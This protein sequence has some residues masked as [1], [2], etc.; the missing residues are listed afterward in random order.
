MS[1]WLE[2]LYTE[3]VL[4]EPSLESTELAAL[5]KLYQS[6]SKPLTEEAPNSEPP[7][8][9]TETDAVILPQRCKHKYHQTNEETPRQSLRQ[10]T[11]GM[12]KK[13]LLVVLIVAQIYVY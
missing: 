6:D 3:E 10:K 1:V 2:Q 12:T 8:T 7:P 9:H 13:L 4:S 5:R 11:T